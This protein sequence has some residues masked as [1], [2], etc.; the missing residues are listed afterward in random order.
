MERRSES[1]EEEVLE[2]VSRLLGQK[3]KDNNGQYLSHIISY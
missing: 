3:S 2:L 1:W